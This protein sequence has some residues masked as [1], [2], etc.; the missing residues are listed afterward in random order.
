MPDVSSARGIVG[1]AGAHR[2][3]RDG[4]NVG[5]VLDS[6]ESG[7]ST[8]AGQAGSRL[9]RPG[10]GHREQ[11]HFRVGGVGQADLVRPPSYETVKKIFQSDDDLVRYLLV[12]GQAADAGTQFL[13]SKTSSHLVAAALATALQRADGDH[14]R[15]VL[16]YA[17]EK[18]FD[19]LE[20]GT[21]P[22]YIK[23]IPN[24]AA[25]E[26]SRA[27][28][29]TDPQGIA[30]GA[31][32]LRLR[33]PDLLKLGE[34]YRNNGSWRGREILPTHWV[35]QVTNPSELNPQYGLMWWLYT[36]N[37]HEIY[38]ARGAEGHLIVVVPDQKSVTAIAS[39]NGPEYAM[40]DEALFPLLNEVIVPGGP[41]RVLKVVGR[42]GTPTTSRCGVRRVYPGLGRLSARGSRPCLAATRGRR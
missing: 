7:K 42:I 14:P 34:L 6:D 1:L 17:R 24:T 30:V 3:W 37:G 25:A 4:C 22:A 40:S 15:S 19:P 33:A 9:P 5:V 10:R 23:P 32:G 35:E 8:H 28:W 21:R 12:K 18:L 20:I 13:Y 38:A 26:F 41:R 27:G 36:W 31:F 29:G 16:D 39:M 11:D 2:S